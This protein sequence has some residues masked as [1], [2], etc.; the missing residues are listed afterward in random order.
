[1]RDYAV[2]RRW[3][4]LALA[5]FDLLGAGWGRWRRVSRRPLAVRRL[6]LVRHR[7]FGDLVTLLPALARARALFPQAQ[8][9]LL[10]E[11]QYRGFLAAAARDCLD[12]LWCPPSAWA[13]WRRR[14]RRFDLA[15]EFHGELPCL[16]LA[17]RH[18]RRVAGYGIRGGGFLLDLQVD[19]PWRLDAS[20]RAVQLVE[21]AAGQPSPSRAA[22]PRRLAPAPAWAAAAAPLLRGL[23]GDFVLLHP[24]CGQP[25]KHWAPERWRALAQ[26]CRDR[27]WAVVLTGS[28]ADRPLCDWLCGGRAAPD[29]G[30]RGPQRACGARPA[31]ARA[32]SGAPWPQVGAALRWGRAEFVS[33]GRAAL[34]NYDRPRT[35]SGFWGPRFAAFRADFASRQS[36]ATPAS[37]LRNLAGQ[38]DWASLAGVV[39]RARCVVAPDT[40]VAH[41][42]QALG[43]PS[44]TLFG[45][46]DPAIWGGGGRTV[47]HRLPCGPCHCSRCP[48]TAGSSQGIAA[49]MAAIRIEEVVQA[50]EAAVSP[51][52]RRPGSRAIPPRH[53]RRA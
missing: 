44:V 35:R 45:P 34:R 42:A 33:R 52:I 11:P 16:L 24:G 3:H 14:S 37:G 21:A 49:C 20:T 18:A 17:R 10:T 15:L 40:G 19:Y 47:S 27:G 9:A 50:L 31:C 38:T 25:A 41:L 28:A 32:D 51:S 43:I 12:E 1:M 13:A 26:R 8:I 5:L 46:T 23:P 6:L 36:G 48:L 22:A 39:A 2:T 30:G 4:R 29:L 7:H 53:A